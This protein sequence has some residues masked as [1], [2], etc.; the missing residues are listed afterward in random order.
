MWGVGCVQI[1]RYVVSVCMYC[2]SM[3]MRFILLQVYVFMSFNSINDLI[4]LVW[5]FLI[6]DPAYKG[7]TPG[8]EVD[9]DFFFWPDDHNRVRTS[10]SSNTCHKPLP[11]LTPL[12]L[13]HPSHHISHYT[14]HYI[15]LL[16]LNLFSALRRCV[17][18]CCRSSMPTRSF[19]I[20]SA[21]WWS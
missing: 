7:F 13:P 18:V 3:D 1:Y 8:A 20:P 4:V 11:S 9:D 12:T 14:S 5:L 16:A 19:P 15:T 2:S 10:Y 6:G 21:W 17:L